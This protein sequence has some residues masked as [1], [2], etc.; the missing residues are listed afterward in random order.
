MVQ[1]VVDLISRSIVFEAR[2]PS[3]IALK[4][5]EGSQKTNASSLPSGLWDTAP[6]N[7]LSGTPPEGYV[8]AYT[9]KFD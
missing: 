5:E 8:Y 4:T 2:V 6:R 1:E 9:L 3:Q 7:F